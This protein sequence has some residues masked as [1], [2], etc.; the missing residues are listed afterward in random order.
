MNCNLCGGENFSILNNKNRLCLN[1]GCC[2]R[3]RA[4]INEYN[5]NI[6]PWKFENKEILYF[7]PNNGIIRYMRNNNLGKITSTNIN[8]NFDP[9]IILN[10][11]SMSSIKN[12]TYDYCILFHVLS[13]VEK[14]VLA[15]NELK[16]SNK[17]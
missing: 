2:E 16:L 15:L 14:D 11:E 6:H 4:F 7:S 17:T 1:C 3:Q 13:A 5:K 12:N 8:T 10:I 9:D